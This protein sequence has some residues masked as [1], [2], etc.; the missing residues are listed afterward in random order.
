M[1]DNLFIK[2]LGIFPVFL[3]FLIINIWNISLETK[4]YI[5]G[6]VILIGFL[7][8]F[9]RRRELRE[10]GKRPFLLLAICLA[11]PILI[12]YFQLEL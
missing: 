5:L 2:S 9:L 4:N 6:L 3:Y 12:L 1:K 7:S 8:F 10:K 11:V